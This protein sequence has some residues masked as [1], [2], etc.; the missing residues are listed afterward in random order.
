ML[1][2]PETVAAHG[3]RCTHARNGPRRL[4]VKARA[5]GTRSAASPLPTPAIEDR[6]MGPLIETL[7]VPGSRLPT[8]LSF[9][10]LRQLPCL[11]TAAPPALPL[12]YIEMEIAVTSMMK[13][14]SVPL[15]VRTLLEFHLV[16]LDV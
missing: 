6:I 14:L 2:S 16:D 4:V 3:G 11:S 5:R 10:R 12:R 7:G 13:V 15:Q 9:P 1:P 8:G